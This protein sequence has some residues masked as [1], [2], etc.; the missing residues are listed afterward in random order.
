MESTNPMYGDATL[1]GLQ[2]LVPMD[3]YTPYK[4]NNEYVRPVMHPLY[5]LVNLGES[6]Q[7]YPHP[8]GQ[9]TE[10]GRFMVGNSRIPSAEVRQHRQQLPTEF[11]PR[12]YG[13]PNRYGAAG[14]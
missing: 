2:P 14:R 4:M 5:G 12:D 10:A 8:Q 6:G 3:Q 13:V 7:I 9:Q 11:A 1:D